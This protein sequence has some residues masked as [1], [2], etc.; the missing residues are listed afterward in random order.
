MRQWSQGPDRPPPRLMTYL[1][2]G[3]LKVLTHKVRRKRLPSSEVLLGVRHGAKHSTSILPNSPSVRFVSPAP[4]SPWSPNSS[5]SY[6]VLGWFS[7]WRSQQSPLSPHP[8]FFLCFLLL[9]MTLPPSC[10]SQN[11]TS[12]FIPHPSLMPIR[13]LPPSAVDFT[14]STA[15][16]AYTS[17]YSPFTSL[18]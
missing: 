7:R 9:E 6:E 2:P 8:M 15:P 17:P 5:R 10:S 13:N 14:S 16:E 18:L 1:N 3:L 12:D 11:L 4:T